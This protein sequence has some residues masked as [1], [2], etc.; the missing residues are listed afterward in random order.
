MLFQALRRTSTVALSG[1]AAD[2]VFGGY[3]WMFNQKAIEGQTFPWLTVGRSM[4]DGTRILR[5]DVRQG[6]D[7]PTFEHDAYE[8]ALAEVPRLQ[9]ESGV[10]ER[11]RELSYLNLTRFLPYLLDRK[12]RMS[13]AQGL[14]VRVPFCDHRLVEYVF[15]VPW[16]LKT[17][18]GHEK[19]IL[20][21]AFA[22]ILPS[23][24]A[25]RRKSPY[26]A[27]SDPGYERLLRERVSRIIEDEDDPTQNLLD[28]GALGGLLKRPLGNTS[29]ASDRAA[30]EAA[31]GLSCWLRDTPVSIAS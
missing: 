24:I 17:F 11:M 5:E 16:A 31:N 9:G 4:V 23:S 8:A 12:D 6:L 26:P 25:E 7:M 19:S 21:A 28:P 14:E 10:E 22:D 20:R 30:L 27:T 2:E 18:D 15:N 3:I 1:E 29:S 13:M